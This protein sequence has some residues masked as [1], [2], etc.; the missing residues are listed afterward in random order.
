[1]LSYIKQPV[2]S[3]A[4]PFKHSSL[5]QAKQPVSSSAVLFK[6]CSPFQ[7]QQSVSASSQ[8][9]IVKT[10]KDQAKPAE[11]CRQISVNSPFS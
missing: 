1:M 11:I 10:G 5:F 8:A 6:Q 3:N 9:A 2:S 4:A 7:A